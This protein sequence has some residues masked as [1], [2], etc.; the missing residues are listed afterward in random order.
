MD[1]YRKAPKLY[2]DSNKAELGLGNYYSIPQRLV[3][4]I[5]S[6]L[7]GK[8]GNQIKLIITLLGTIGNGSFGVSEKWVTDSCGFS[9]PRYIDARKALIKLNWVELK[10]GA[11]IVRIKNMLKDW[12]EM[13]D[14][15]NTFCNSMDEVADD[16]IV[17][18]K[19]EQPYVE[20]MD[21]SRLNVKEPFR[22]GM[23]NK[24]EQIINKEI[25]IEEEP[26]QEINTDI[27]ISRTGELEY[28]LKRHNITEEDVKAIIRNNNIDDVT[29][30]ICFFHYMTKRDDCIVSDSVPEI[31]N[32]LSA[33]FECNKMKDIRSGYELHKEDII[34]Y[35]SDEQKNIF[36]TS[37]FFHQ[38]SSSATLDDRRVESLQ[39]LLS[40][41][42]RLGTSFFKRNL[43][44]PVAG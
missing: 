38:F 32:I 12:K 29:D 30:F 35:A 26:A 9:Q 1:N 6:K 37:S 23:R 11:I 20:R 2:H 5:F 10:N 43:G 16:D 21:D 14:K 28:I 25:T 3:D 22:K 31:K 44:R 18:P 42:A 7:D 15:R 33:Y 13:E 27:K 8:K 19:D 39:G 34:E 40:R 4:V 17:T 41:G 36:T 24:E